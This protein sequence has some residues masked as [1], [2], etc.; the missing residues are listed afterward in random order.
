MQAQ[1]QPTSNSSSISIRSV[2]LEL[3]GEAFAAVLSGTRSP[4]DIPDT[5]VLL[6]LVCKTWWNA[7][8]ATPRLWS[9]LGVDL[10]DGMD[11]QQVARW[12][13]RA[14]NA[15]KFLTVDTGMGCDHSDA[16]GCLVVA[17]GFTDFLSTGPSLYRT[18]ETDCYA[19]LSTH[20]KAVD[21]PTAQDSCRGHPSNEDHRHLVATS[22]H[23]DQELNE[24]D[25]RLMKK[26]TCIRNMLAKLT[27][28]TLPLFWPTTLIRKLQTLKLRLDVQDPERYGTTVPF[29]SPDG[30][31]VL[32]HLRILR[33][34]E[35]QLD[36]GWDLQILR[37][38][39]TP[40]LEEL[41]VFFSNLDNNFEDDPE[42]W[43]FGDEVGELVK[44]S[45]CQGTFKRL[46][47]SN[48]YLSSRGFERMLQGLPGLTHLTL[49]YINSDSRI[50]LEPT[51]LPKN[52]PPP[53]V[54]NLQVLEFIHLENPFFRY[55]DVCEFVLARVDSG[56]AFRELTIELASARRTRN[57]RHPN[58]SL[59]KKGVAVQINFGI[60]P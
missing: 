42:G 16:L 39:K 8:M 52:N 3:L 17:S 33:I 4:C 29:S 32:P 28:F 11:F 25:A 58:E 20:L 26:G 56:L 23:I 60:S 59:R 10:R 35:I 43:D 40:S 46:R 41:D 15:P 18:G 38:F 6:N 47:I 30:P 19:Y 31:L 21:F 55:Q 1:D 48:I 45:G 27:E 13:S 5:L 14:G 2:P 49:D 9:S 54:L 44:R 12:L 50:F 24:K 36:L 57:G 22:L 37:L 7:A 51:F 53:F 34:H